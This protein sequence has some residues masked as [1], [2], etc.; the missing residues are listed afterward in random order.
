MPRQTV[1]GPEVLAAIHVRSQGLPRLINA[2]CDNL[3]LTAFALET[4]AATLEMLDEVSEDMRLDWPGRRARTPRSRYGEA[5]VEP[6][7]VYNLA[8]NCAAGAGGATRGTRV[9][10]G[11]RPTENPFLS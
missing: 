3:L 5:P 7:A 6:A 1:F 10:E 11:V 8:G 2:I 4:R 9:D